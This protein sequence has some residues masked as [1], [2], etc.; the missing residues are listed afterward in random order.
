MSLV[1]SPVTTHAIDITKSQP[2]LEADVT[3]LNIPL[4]QADITEFE[5]PPNTKCMS[6]ISQGVRKLLSLG[7]T[8]AWAELFGLSTE[9]QYKIVLENGLT[10]HPGGL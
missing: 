6:G 4:P 3:A 10:S 8:N 7:M 2:P 5:M 1:M 9:L